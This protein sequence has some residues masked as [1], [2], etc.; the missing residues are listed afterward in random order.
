M[1]HDFTTDKNGMPSMEI[2][3][4]INQGQSSAQVAWRHA[5]ENMNKD[6]LSKERFLTKR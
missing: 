6:L 4:G 3:S 5:A 2:V 1:I